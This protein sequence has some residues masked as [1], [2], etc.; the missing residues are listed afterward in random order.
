MD[1]LI[2]DEWN[3][4]KALRDEIDFFKT[5]VSNSIDNMNSFVPKLKS[6][7]KYINSTVAA[8]P[9]ILR[10]GTLHTILWYIRGKRDN[11]SY[12]LLDGAVNWVL[13][14]QTE[15]TSKGY[16]AVDLQTKLMFAKDAIANLR[17]GLDANA[18]NY[19]KSIAK[20]DELS[21]DI[22]T[23]IE[24]IN[25]LLGALFYIIYY[26]ELNLYFR[27]SSSSKWFNNSA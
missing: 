8:T 9:T 15:L 17:D 19:V 21:G 6:V 5:Q 27:N 26:I 25:A 12:Y 11:K 1:V 14:R 23:N 4:S 7:V 10:R 18:Q 22:C 13:R 24:G 3:N 16:R 20:I 2:T